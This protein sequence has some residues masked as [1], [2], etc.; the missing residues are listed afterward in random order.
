MN[1]WT[2]DSVPGQ[3]GRTVVITGGNTDFPAPRRPGCS[4]GRRRRDRAG[5][6]GAPPAR[7]QTKIRA[8]APQA[9]VD[10]VRLDLASLASVR[11]AADQLRASYP[12]IDLLINNAGGVNPRYQRTEDGFER[13]LAT[14]HLGP[15]ALT[16]LVLDRLL[17]VPGSRVV[18][19]S[20]I[21]HRRGVINFD[22]LQADRGYRSQQAYFQSKLAN[23]L[24]TYELQARLAAAGAATI[25]VAAHPG[26]ARTGI[27]PGTSSQRR[28]DHDEP[29]AARADLVADAEPA[30]RRAGHGAGRDRP[31]GRAAETTSRPPGR[32]QFHRLSGPG[33][34]FRAVPRP[35][36]SPAAVGRYTGG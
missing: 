33:R 28:P 15:F 9:R 1:R 29:P 3:E 19:V 34:V 35:G 23:L 17:P 27:R 30:G 24:F 13:T 10:L 25:A 32:S 22:D 21:G 2:E 18:T 31:E 11:E 12:A 36:G 26:N 14:N 7:P 5:L 4:P 8:T 20:S 16:G 6:P